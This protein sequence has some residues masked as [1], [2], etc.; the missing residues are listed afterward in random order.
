M[1]S[2]VLN[3][4]YEKKKIIRVKTMLKKGIPVVSGGTVLIQGVSRN[5]YPLYIREYDPISE[6]YI[7]MVITPYR[8][9]ICWD[10]Y[11]RFKGHLK[12]GDV[13]P[14]GLSHKASKRFDIDKIEKY[15]A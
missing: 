11:G 12:D 14:S 7:G 5:G 3:W 2:K 10:R 4:Y 9:E 8:R 13:I 1:L 15:F 6:S